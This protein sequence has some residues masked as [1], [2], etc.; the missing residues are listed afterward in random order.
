MINDFEWSRQCFYNSKMKK[1]SAALFAYSHLSYR[2]Q[3]K[4]INSLPSTFQ[5]FLFIDNPLPV[6]YDSFFSKVN[7]VPEDE[8]T[9]LGCM[10]QQLM[11]YRDKL[12]QFV[13]LKNKYE[14]DFLLGKYDICASILDQIDKICLSVWSLENR[15]LLKKNFEGTENAL[16][17]KDEIGDAASPLA[18]LMTTLLWSKVDAKYSLSPI[19]QKLHQIL[20]SIGFSEQT[21]SFYIYKTLKY[22]DD[23]RYINSMIFALMSSVID[24]YEFVL[25]MIIHKAKSLSKEDMAQVRTMLSDLSKKINDQRIEKLNEHFLFSK[26]K[27]EDKAHDDLLNNYDKGNFRHVVEIA[28]DYLLQ[29]VCDMDAFDVYVKALLYLDE[30]NDI[31]TGFFAK[32]SYAEQILQHLFFYLKKGPKSQMA[33]ARLNVISNQLSSLRVGNCLYEKLSSYENVGYTLDKYEIYDTY[34]RISGMDI[35]REDYDHVAIKGEKPLFLKQRAAVLAFNE[36]EIQHQDSNLIKFYNDAYFCNPLIV[37]QI[38]TKRLIDRHDI[39]LNLL[40]LDA[41]E[42]CVFYA[43]TGAPRHMVYHFF[44][45]HIKAQQS[46]FPSE[47]LLY[48]EKTL[49]PLLVCFFEKV[50]TIEILKLYIKLFPTSDSVLEERLKILTSLSKLFGGERYLREVTRIKRRQKT[51]KR[52]QD[53]DQRMIFVDENAIKETE[54]ADVEKQFSVYIQTE[55]NLETKQYMI[56]AEGVSVDDINKGIMKVKTEKVQYKRLLFRQMFLDIRKQFLI[57][58]NNGLDFYLSTRIRHGTLLNQLRS[59]FEE[60]NLITNKQDGVYKDNTVMVDRVLCLPIEERGR[61]IEIL[62]DFSKEIDDYILHIKNEVIQVQAMDLPEQ[63]K[64]AI[65]NY[66][67]IINELAITTLYIEKISAIDD[68]VEFVEVVFA[69][70]WEKTE[71]LLGKM[72]DY[73][74]NVKQ[75]LTKKI[76]KLEHDVIEIIGENKLLDGFIEKATKSIEGM[77]ENV[78]KVKKWFYRG[79]CDDDDFQL[80]DVVD[81][82]KESVSIHRNTE[83]QLSIDDNSVTWIKGEYFRRVSDLFMIFF[84]NMIDY[85]NNVKIDL[86]NNVK[87][88][89]NE[90]L[91]EITISNNLVEL[92]VPRMKKYIEETREKLGNPQYL[93]FASKEKGSGHFKAYNMLHNMLPFDKNA[94]TMGINE[95][96]FE[97]KIKIDTTYIKTNEDINS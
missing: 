9:G 31:P 54:L 21:F 46:Q 51:N 94:F 68:Y 53:L 78:E 88:E 45:K 23:H 61:V 69:F 58:Y 11:P 28:P 48:S 65:F 71:V 1:S 8:M 85:T 62:R 82:C 59:A 83:F 57:S 76:E 25:D 63:F 52:V 30:K 49:S 79:K 5:R 96:R 32:G 22:S 70:L 77:T 7:F 93:Q 87:I 40:N 74:D 24:I 14:N 81:A 47:L 33:Y 72:R 16:E 19:E 67:E 37:S 95:N 86:D 36:M 29:N 18:K 39:T 10:V 64:Q 35:I 84:N 2:D 26:T 4:L 13:I 66:D 27:N 55:S 6:S 91:I 89:E 80:R 38:N 41:L 17:F 56:E 15:L 90:N 42:T 3:K 43:I 44:K 50:C 12:N 20:H 92:D 60:N 73:L 97:I 34:S 75:D